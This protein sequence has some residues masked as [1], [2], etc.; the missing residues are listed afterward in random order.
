[1]KTNTDLELFKG[2]KALSDASFPKKCAACG[3]YYKSV[4]AFIQHTEVVGKGAGGFKSTRDELDRPVV[5]LYR[6]CPCGSTLMDAF[7][8][9]RDRSAAGI[10][11]PDLFGQLMK[12][13]ANKGL[14]WTLGA[15]KIRVETLNSTQIT[16]K[17]FI[18][19]LT[20]ALGLVSGFAEEKKEATA[21]VVGMTG[22]T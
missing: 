20:L 10:K 8:D 15:R 21:Y 9:R 13:L 16:M 17:K 1:M 12:I 14:P 19:A 3:R 11:K 7:D 18:I 4:E 6:N 2:L 22:V 5:E